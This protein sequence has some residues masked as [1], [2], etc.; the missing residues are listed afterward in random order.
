MNI[1]V[2][3]DD[4]L[5][6]Q[7]ISL[8][9]KNAGHTVKLC[10]DGYSAM[11]ALE[12]HAYDVV[13]TDLLMPGKDGMAVIEHLKKLDLNTPVLVISGGRNDDPEELLA[14]AAYFAGETL[15]KPVQK[16]PL[17]KAIENLAI[18]SGS[19]KLYY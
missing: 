12:E 16:E 9:L 13:V 3:D 6:R 10:P 7:V 1:L 11:Q 14:F 18:H 19:D 17:L 4:A 2:A 8:M 15:E 5:T